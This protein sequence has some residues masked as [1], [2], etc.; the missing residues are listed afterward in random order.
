[1]IRKNY[2]I[3]FIIIFLT[4]IIFAP[5]ISIAGDA[6]SNPNSFKPGSVS[7]DDTKSVTNKAN[8][9]IGAIV[10]I[11]I[12]IAAI[13]LAVIG[14]KYM[15]GSVEEKAEYKKTMIPYLIG[16]VLLVASSIVV[17]IIANLVQGTNLAK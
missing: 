14:I 15:V 4:F 7:D 3:I 17:S 13:T 11:G 9:I 8:N 16:V 2:L 12:V 1:M 5:T 10:T 6:I